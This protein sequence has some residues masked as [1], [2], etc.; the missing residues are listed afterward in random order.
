MQTTGD[1][2][3]TLQQTSRHDRAAEGL[4]VHGHTRIDSLFGADALRNMRDWL[5]GVQAQGARVPDSYQP[6]F[7]DA[8]G[9]PRLRKLRRLFWNDPDFWT[10]MLEA[11]GVFDFARATVPGTPCL[12]LHAAF[13]K[14]ARI[15]SAV[16]PHQDRAFW[17]HP[18]PG[19][20][21]V[22]VAIDAATP[23]NGCLEIYPGSH[24]MGLLPHLP[25][26]DSPWHETV[27]P[28]EHGLRAVPAPAAAGDAIVWHADM[29]HSSAPNRSAADRRGMVMVF[30]DSSS[31]DFEALDHY[32]I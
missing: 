27:T 11:N 31:K 16:A 21:T 25:R 3:A 20:V 7:E 26:P 8:N 32:D 28:E 23:G 12:I 17:I 14:P 9:T 22:W 5:S 24:R 10:P 18:Y 30:A 15:G 29:L 4:A 13:C 19:A 1:T 2:S 6:Q